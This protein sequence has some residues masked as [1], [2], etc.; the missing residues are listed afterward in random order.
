MFVYIDADGI[1]LSAL[2]F[3]ISSEYPSA[4]QKYFATKLLD[5][6]ICIQIH[7]EK[8][9]KTIEDD[10]IDNHED[11]LVIDCRILMVGDGMRFFTFEIPVNFKRVLGR[12]QLSM[13][14]YTTSFM[15]EFLPSMSRF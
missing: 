7:T 15:N 13:L 1:N 8:M 9:S 11:D 10:M 6:E 14:S 2:V 3:E 4:S 5:F 12:A